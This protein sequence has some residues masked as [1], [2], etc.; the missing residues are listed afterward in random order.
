MGWRNHIRPFCHQLI[1]RSS[2]ILLEQGSNVP[3]SS[4]LCDG[5]RKG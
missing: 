5:K 2:A 4:T 1:E 3:S